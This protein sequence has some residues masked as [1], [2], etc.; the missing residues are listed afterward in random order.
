MLC[1]WVRWI[2]M[3][4]TPA[5]MDIGLHCARSKRVRP[6]VENDTSGPLVAARV[7]KCLR[8][9]TSVL[10]TLVGGASPFA[11][12][13]PRRL[14][15]SDAVPLSATTSV[16]TQ[17]AAISRGGR[18]SPAP[19]AGGGAATRDPFVGVVARRHGRSSSVRPEPRSSRCKG[20]CE[21]V[22]NDDTNFVSFCACM[23]A[24][25]RRC[26]CVYV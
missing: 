6:A 22:Q 20:S 8:A 21:K 4:S 15:N 9:S 14:A 5:R 23:G 16:A 3:P 7:Q 24:F 25:V 12:P 26:F 19:G 13:T 10:L 2:S 17:L 18:G 1:L 11:S